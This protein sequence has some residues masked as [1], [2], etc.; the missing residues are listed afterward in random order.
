VDEYREEIVITIRKFY[1]EHNRIPVRREMW[2]PY[3]KARK[4]FGT[5]NNAIKAAGYEPNPVLFAK[6]YI[7]NDGHKCDSLSEKIIDDWLSARDIPHEVNVSYEGTS[8]TA[9]FRV[10][11]IL[12]EFLGLS[13]EV[14]EYDRLVEEK[15]KLWKKHNLDVIELYPKDIFPKSQLDKVLKRLTTA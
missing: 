14:S 9:D 6:K 7:A 1:E 13:G 4:G 10:G 5:W 3:R 15:R 11:S 2:A 8:M 12:I